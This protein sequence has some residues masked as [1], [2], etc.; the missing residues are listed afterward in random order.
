MDFDTAALVLGWVARYAVVGLA[1]AASAAF[2]G[3]KA[4]QDVGMRGAR[5]V[6]ALAL[7][8]ALWPVAVLRGAARIVR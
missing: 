8:V 4:G 2:A 7:Y 3:S 6:L 1:C 5:D